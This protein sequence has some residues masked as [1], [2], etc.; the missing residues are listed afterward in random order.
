MSS[1]TGG[2]GYLLKD[3]MVSRRELEE[4]SERIASGGTVPDPEVV[5]PLLGRRHDPL[6]SLTPREREVLTHMAEGRP[7]SPIT[8]AMGAGTVAVEKNVASSS[9]KLGLHVSDDDH[10]LVR[11]VLAWAQRRSLRLRMTL[12]SARDDQ[13]QR[14]DI[15]G[16]HLDL[17]A[18]LFDTVGPAEAVPPAQLGKV[19]RIAVPAGGYGRTFH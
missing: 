7:N 17:G 9:Q 14:R 1:G 2:V 16:R 18:V 8:T 12:D 6:G 10:R 15:G 5:A 11:A 19:E 13:N 4:V 3:R